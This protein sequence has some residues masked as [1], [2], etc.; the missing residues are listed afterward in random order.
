MLETLQAKIVL[1]LTLVLL[2]LQGSRGYILHDAKTGTRTLL[3]T[4]VFGI[5]LALLFAY[6]TNCLIRGECVIRSWIRTLIFLVIAILSVVIL[7]LTLTGHKYRLIHTQDLLTSWAPLSPSTPVFP[8]ADGAGGS[9][10]VVPSW[11]GIS[12]GGTLGKA[13]IPVLTKE[14]GA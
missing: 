10:E 5:P 11:T 13:G 12:E 1:G 7:V 6:D 2:V 4:L 14:P 9:G 8:S 3:W